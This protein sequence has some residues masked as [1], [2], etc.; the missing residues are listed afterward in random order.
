MK[1]FKITVNGT[2][3]QVSVG[4][5]S[6]SP[7]EVTV[8]GEPFRVEIAE[9][10]PTPPSSAATSATPP[11]PTTASTAREVTAP[12]PGTIL[13]INV[14]AGDRVTTGQPLCSLEAMKMKSPIR[15]P[16]DGTIAEVRARSGQ[17]VAYGAV[18]FVFE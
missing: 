18:L 1:D 4:D 5:L 11:P 9:Q 16:R 12:M 10:T 8:D 2:T 15:S 17:T 3:Y 13:E 6:A 7:V 14:G